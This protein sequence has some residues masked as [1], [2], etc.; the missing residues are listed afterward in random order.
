MRNFDLVHVIL[1]GPGGQESQGIVSLRRQAWLLYT[2]GRFDGHHANGDAGVATIGITESDFKLL[3]KPREDPARYRELA[4]WDH[5]ID[6]L[7]HPRFRLEQ[8]T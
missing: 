1:L 2:W 6:L 5:V 7:N 8:R 3:L 4:N